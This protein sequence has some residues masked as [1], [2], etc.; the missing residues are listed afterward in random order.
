MA[1]DPNSTEDAAGFDL[2]IDLEQVASGQNGAVVIYG[3]CWLLAGVALQTHAQRGTSLDAIVD[4]FT[5]NLRS[6]I[7]RLSTLPPSEV[8]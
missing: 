5:M 8:H 6:C 2:A 1:I 3:C 7:T 4:L